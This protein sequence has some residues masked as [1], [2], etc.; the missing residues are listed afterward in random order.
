[1]SVELGISQNKSRDKI[2][3]VEALALDALYFV[4]PERT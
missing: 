4:P 3:S 1:M 2:L